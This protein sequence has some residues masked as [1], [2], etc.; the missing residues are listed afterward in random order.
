MNNKPLTEKELRLLRQ[1]RNSIVHDRQSP[2]IRKLGDLLGYPSPRSVAVLIEQLKRKGILLRKKNGTLWILKDTEDNNMRAKTLDVPL[3]GS[4]SC[5]IPIFAEENI[6]AMIPVSQKLAHPPH[7]YFLL[8]AKGDS[9]NQKGINDGDLV[10]IR[11]QQTANNG[12][13][14]VALIDDEATIKELWRTKDAII[15]K[16]RSHNKKHQPIILHEDF[17]IQGVVVTTIPKL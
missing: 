2:S 10:L 4:I 9:M 16:P 6:E 12:D 17:E 1:I 7:R 14:V 11:Q 13:S 3:V 5:G 8:R 15:L